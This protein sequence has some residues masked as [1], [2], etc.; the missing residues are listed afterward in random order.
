M[1]T[2]GKLTRF[3][4]HIVTLEFLYTDRRNERL[5][6]V[7]TITLPKCPVGM[8]KMKY[9]TQ[10]PLYPGVLHN[11]VTADEWLDLLIRYGWI[12]RVERYGTYWSGDIHKLHWL[13]A[14]D[15]KVGKLVLDERLMLYK[16]NIKWS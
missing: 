8:N 15:V 3:I 6:F 12:I 9:V 13:L 10:R 11:Y 14:E 2:L 1:F 5:A 4:L 7:K 16:C